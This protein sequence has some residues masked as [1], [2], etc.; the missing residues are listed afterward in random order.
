MKVGSY[1]KGCR[2]E[3]KKITWPSKKEVASN[4]RVVLLSTIFSAIFLGLV[5]FLVARGST[6]LFNL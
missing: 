4:V 3:F 1:I 5:D 2:E 6:W